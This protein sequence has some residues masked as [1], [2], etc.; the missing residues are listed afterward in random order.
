MPTNNGSSWYPLFHVQ[1]DVQQRKVAKERKDANKA[2][3]VVVQK[4]RAYFR[5]VRHTYVGAGRRCLSAR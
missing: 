2:K 5:G 3:S 1:A 4:V